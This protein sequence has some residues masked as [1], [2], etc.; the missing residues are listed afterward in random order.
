ML[1]YGRNVAGGRG[2]RTYRRACPAANGLSRIFE[3]IGWLNGPLI[4]SIRCLTLGCPEGRRSALSVHPPD[5]YG[6][7]SKESSRRRHTFSWFAVWALRARQKVPY[8][9]NYNACWPA[10]DPISG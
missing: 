2:F 1:D 9:L 10:S 5:D 4:R 3:D 8:H 7:D 6:I